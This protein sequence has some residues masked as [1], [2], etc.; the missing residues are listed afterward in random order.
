MD[1]AG[2]CPGVAGLGPEISRVGVTEEPV[3]GTERRHPGSEAC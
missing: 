2:V 1:R 3:T